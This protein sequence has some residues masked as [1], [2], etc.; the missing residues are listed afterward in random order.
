MA[1]IRNSRETAMQYLQEE[2]R[3]GRVVGLIG[4]QQWSYIQVSPI[5]VSV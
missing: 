5:G 2:I 3:L 1:T 4:L